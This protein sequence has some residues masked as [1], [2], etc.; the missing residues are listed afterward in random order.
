M[1]VASQKLPLG[2]FRLN[3]VTQGQY[4]H[5]QV[6]IRGAISRQILV[7]LHATADFVLRSTILFHPITIT[8]YQNK[9]I[10]LVVIGDSG[11]N[12]LVGTH[13]DNANFCRVVIM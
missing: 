5:Y 7:L 12:E 4:T 13:C 3:S 6:K 9:N 1:I 8:N 10:L 11:S 2:Y